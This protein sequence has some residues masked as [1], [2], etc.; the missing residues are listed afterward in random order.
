MGNFS[1]SLAL[2]GISKAASHLIVGRVSATASYESAWKEWAGWCSGKGINL[3]LCD[4]NPILEFLGELFE[5][6]YDYRTSGIH[7]SAISLYHD[8]VDEMKVGV[9][10]NTRHFQ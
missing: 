2:S 8:L 9:Q 6:G 1:K 5:V 4:I 7:R 10:P 3:F